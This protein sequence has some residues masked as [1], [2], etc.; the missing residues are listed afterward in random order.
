MTIESI[1]QNLKDL[2][3]NLGGTPKG[4]SSA[5]L[6][7]EL[8]DLVRASDAGIVEADVTDDDMNQVF[9]D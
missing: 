1:S 8:E 3:V 5:E 7:D 6:L 2:I 4:K 9:G